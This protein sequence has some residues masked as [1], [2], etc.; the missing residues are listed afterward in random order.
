MTATHGLTYNAAGHVD[1]AADEFGGGC[2]H[3]LN[4][5]RSHTDLGKDGPHNKVDPAS[6]IENKPWSKDQRQTA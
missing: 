2:N 5:A 6:A 4:G 1:R 3:R